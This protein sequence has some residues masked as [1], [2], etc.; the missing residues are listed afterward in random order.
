MEEFR[1]VWIMA[2]GGDP[3]AQQS[4]NKFLNFDN[5]IERSNLPLRSD[6]QVLSCA[7]YASQVCFDDAEDNPFR[8]VYE[9]FSAGFNGLKSKKSDQFVELNK[10]T[11]NLMELKDNK[12]ALKRSISDK[13]LGRNKPE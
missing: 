13:L 12:D 11:P 2:K 7:K 8:L 10:L 4:L 5:P 9:V 1:Q 3:L 6:V